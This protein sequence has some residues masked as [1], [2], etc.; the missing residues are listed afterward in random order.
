[1]DRQI[2]NFT[3]NEQILTCDN[4]IRISTN[5]VNYIEAHFALGENWSGYDSVRAVWF[6]DFQTISTVLDSQGT[7][8]VPFEVM[9]RKGN[10]KV[11]LVGSISENDVLTDRL[12]SYPVIAV[13]VDCIAQITGAETNPITPSQFEQY[14]AIVRDLVDS[15]KDIDHIELNDDYTLTIYYSDGTSYTTTSIRG[16]QGADGNGI[17]NITK[18]ST[19]GL[20]DTY[21]ITFTDGSHTDFTVTNGAKGDT[22]ATPNIGI[23][24]V[25]T[26]NAGSDATA[27]IAGTAENPV[28]NLGIPKGADGSLT[29]SVLASTYSTSKKYSVGDYVYYNGNL[30]RCTTAIT[31]AEAWTSAHWAQVALA[32]DVSDLKADINKLGFSVV[33]GALCMTYT[34]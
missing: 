5:K 27:S 29:S 3:A 22:G 10:V 28:L 13:V 18:K 2:L 6:N 9:K 16:E 34:E 4:P 7:T 20:V 17:Q 31:T 14:V 15:V 21:R 30:Y 33:N 1:M 11:N 19:S 8:F 25:T 12:T 24:T 26:L 32:N 23:G